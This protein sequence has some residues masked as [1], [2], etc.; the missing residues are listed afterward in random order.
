MNILNTGSMNR[1]NPWKRKTRRFISTVLL[2]S[3]LTTAFAGLTGSATRIDFDDLP[4]PP[5]GGKPVPNGYAGLNWANVSYLN[6]SNNNF[7]PSGYQNLVYTPPHV[8]FMADDTQSV[9]ISG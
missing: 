1:I 5:L 9:M 7:G 3:S 4:V 6:T 8:A 2:L